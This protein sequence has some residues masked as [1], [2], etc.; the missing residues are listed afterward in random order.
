[1]WPAGLF[2]CILWARKAPFTAG[3]GWGII[4]QGGFLFIFDL[5]HAV[6]VPRREAALPAFEI[7]SGRSTRPSCD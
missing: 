2:C 4:V 6:A 1:M 7:F 3:N 5:L